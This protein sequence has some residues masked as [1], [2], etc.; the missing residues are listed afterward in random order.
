LDESL[1]VYGLIG[2]A[3]GNQAVLLQ[4]VRIVSMRQECELDEVRCYTSYMFL[5]PV[6]IMVCPLT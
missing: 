6:T 5:P 1:G 2:L 4:A 3:F